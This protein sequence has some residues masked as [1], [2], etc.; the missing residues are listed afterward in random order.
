MQN[1]YK[2]VTYSMLNVLQTRLSF[3]GAEEYMINQAGIEVRKIGI[4]RMRAVEFLKDWHDALGPYMH[5][6]GFSSRVL[7]RNM[8]LT[9]LNVIEQFPFCAQSTQIAMLNIQSISTQLEPED[10]RSLKEF[11]MLLIKKN[12]LF[13]FESERSTAS[14]NLAQAVRMAMELKRHSELV[15]PADPEDPFEKKWLKFCK[16]KLEHIQR[17]WNRNLEDQ[18]AEDEEGGVA[19]DDDEDEQEEE[20]MN[21]S[22]DVIS[23]CLRGVHEKKKQMM[24]RNGAKR[25]DQQLEASGDDDRVAK[26][27]A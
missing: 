7:R 4:R 2:D 13:T 27:G 15:E 19:A 20:K 14:M 23:T 16:T 6:P 22:E 24:D 17:R 11:V 25:V 18:Y 8:L 9:M 3:D 5:N 26:E 10:V 21:E 12:Q 1:A